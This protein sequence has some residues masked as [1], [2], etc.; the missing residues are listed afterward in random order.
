MSGSK[1]SFACGPHGHR[2]RVRERKRGGNVYLCS[3]DPG[4]GGTKK[5]S[6]GFPVRDAEGKLIK[7]AVDEAKRAAVGASNKLIKGETPGTDPTSLGELFDAFRREEAREMSGRHGRGVRRELELL[8]RFLGRDLAVES[9]SLG[10]WNAVKRARASGEID[11][12]GHRVLKQ[13]TRKERS[14]RTVAKTLKV[15]RQACRFGARWRRPDGSYLLDRD[16]T[17]GLDLPKTKDPNRPV[18]SDEL[19]AGMLEAA[20]VVTRRVRGAGENR[21]VR[22]CLRELLLVAA[23]TGAR[24]GAILALRWSDWDPNA[25]THGTLTWR[26][27]HDKGGRTRTTP[28]PE[29]VR[30]ALRAQRRRDPGVGEAP[31]F[32]APNSD[33]HLRVD[34]AL[35]WLGEA[36]RK[37]RP[38]GEHVKGF[39]WHALRRRW[40]N[41][42]KGRPAVDVAHLGG[43]SGP[44]VMETVYQRATMEDMERALDAGDPGRAA[45]GRS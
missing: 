17:R 39:G 2:V 4:F 32:P 36:E 21:E 13:E 11:S 31:I 38:D 14:P 16:P 12:H 23:G 15:L 24:I 40:A 41:K 19:L 37:T 6:L 44:H 34:V 3:Y 28:V 35:R 9:I 30:E 26:A 1:W 43:W 42:M 10:E 25:G 7:D 18:C 27:E 20:P 45:T 5:T 29:S 8:E 22:T 33:G